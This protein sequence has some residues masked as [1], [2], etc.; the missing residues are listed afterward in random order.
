M[1]YK[2]NGQI[3]IHTGWTEPSIIMYEALLNQS[4]LLCSKLMLYYTLGSLYTS[5][6][7]A[8]MIMMG[9]ASLHQLYVQLIIY[10]PKAVGSADVQNSSSFSD[11][12]MKKDQL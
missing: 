4:Q 2:I 5:M 1:L 6:N 3:P 7:C 11:I 8:T 12:P 10:T 9:S